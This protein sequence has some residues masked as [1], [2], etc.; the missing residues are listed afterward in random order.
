MVEMQEARWSLTFSRPQEDRLLVHLSGNW[1]AEDH[2]PPAADVDEQIR[3]DPP[4]RRI[5]FDTRELENWDSGLLTF[6]IKVREE[7]SKR[8]VVLDEEGLPQGVRRLL[9]LAAAV[10]SRK[11]Q[12][13]RRPGKDS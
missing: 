11:G 2:L 3:S 10:R 9:A 4:T 1:R 5:L 12:G 7:G 8:N 6:L 13:R